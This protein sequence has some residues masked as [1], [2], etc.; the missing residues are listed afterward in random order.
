[1]SFHESAFFL[2]STFRQ[3]PQG[4]QVA[5]QT[6]SFDGGCAGGAD[7][8]DMAEALTAIRVGDVDLYRGDAHRFYR[9][10]QRSEER[11]VG[12]ECRL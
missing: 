11:R 6:A 3:Q 1:M 7:V 10:Q 9:V 5:L 8:R 4:L 12:K 2:I